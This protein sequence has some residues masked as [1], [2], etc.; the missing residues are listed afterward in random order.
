M[1]TPIHHHGPKGTF[2]TPLYFTANLAVASPSITTFASPNT[3]HGILS[4][5]GASF[6]EKA[7][8]KEASLFR[9]VVQLAPIVVFIF[10]GGREGR[11]TEMLERIHQCYA[12]SKGALCGGIIRAPV[13]ALPCTHPRLTAVHPRIPLHCR[14][15]PTAVR[16]DRRHLSRVVHRAQSP[17][18]PR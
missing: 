17:G 6:Q 9:T 12:S 18:R 13:S 7:A 3:R 1:L 5:N 8:P 11:I 14:H 16:L 4:L 2:S 15:H 10:F